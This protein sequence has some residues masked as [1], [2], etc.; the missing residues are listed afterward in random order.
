MFFLQ[1][2][3]TNSDSSFDI[4]MRTLTGKILTLA[5]SSTMSIEDVKELIQ[6]KEGNPPDQQR[7]IFAGK[8]L[9]DGR[10]LSDYNIQPDSTLHMVLRLRGGMYHLTSGRLD[11]SRL[12][13]TSAKAIKNVL[14][15]KFEDIKHANHLSP[16]ELQNSVL[17]A[18]NLLSDLLNEIEEFSL[19]KNIPNLKT[20]LSSGTK[21]DDDNDDS[22]DDD[23]DNSNDQ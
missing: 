20:I 19:A 7:L 2:D 11:F 8:Q 21:E 1:I 13:S 14:A 5:V 22:D 10:T 12:P 15:F 9:E 17:Q 4:F 18:Q 3:A 23:E 6:N 16:A